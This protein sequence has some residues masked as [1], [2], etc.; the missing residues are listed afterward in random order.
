MPNTAKER[1][2]IM[3]QVFVLVLVAVEAL[4][5]GLVAGFLELLEVSGFGVLLVLFVLGVFGVFGV[6]GVL[7][8]FGVFPEVPVS[9]RISTSLEGTSLSG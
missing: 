9:S 6:F 2:E 3:I 7:E 4:V 8:V 5:P 1:R